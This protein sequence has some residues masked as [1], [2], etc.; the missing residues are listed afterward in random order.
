M[1]Y[2]CYP[3]L[4]NNPGDVCFILDSSGSIGETGWSAILYLV[5]RVVSRLD[6]SGGYHR[7]AL[8]TIANKAHVNLLLS[9]LHTEDDVIER[10]HTLPFK[11]Q[12]TNMSGALYVTRKTVFQESNGDRR[13]INNVVVTISDGVPNVAENETMVEATSLKCEG[14][15]MVSIGMGEEMNM[16]TLHDMAYETSSGMLYPIA[17]HCA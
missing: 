5:S 7:V 16:T 13:Y 4:G 10:L 12:K 6:V 9:E 8:V 15:R 2:V 14:A 17:M 3:E 1:Q 11:D